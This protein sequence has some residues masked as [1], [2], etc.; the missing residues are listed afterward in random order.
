V[1]SHGW[2]LPRMRADRKPHIGEY[3]TKTNAIC[4]FSQ[5]PAASE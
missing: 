4:D 5:I 2:L 1:A 3:D